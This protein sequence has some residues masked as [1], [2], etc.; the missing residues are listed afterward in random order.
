[1][2]LAVF[3]FVGNVFATEEKFS[4]KLIQIGWESGVFESENHKDL[5]FG[6]EMT[7][8]LMVRQKISVQY[9]I[10]KTV[11]IKMAASFGKTE[12][13]LEIFGSSAGILSLGN[14]FEVEAKIYGEEFFNF[15]PY[16]GFGVNYAE[17]NQIKLLPTGDSW[18]PLFEIGFERP[19]SETIGTA[20]YCQLME[21]KLSTN[22]TGI[23]DIIS[24]LNGNV[25]IGLVYRP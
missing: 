14:Q 1:M 23:G 3:T 10:M 9:G 4:D 15:L 12:E 5:P 6:F 20:I 8:H 11:A 24:K 21:R 19:I 16:M 7:P 17:I 22:I 18:S 2:L 13:N 25:Y